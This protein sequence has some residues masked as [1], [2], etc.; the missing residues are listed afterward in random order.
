MS[1][2][3]LKFKYLKVNLCFGYPFGF[4]FLVVDIYN[5]FEYFKKTNSVQVILTR[6]RVGFFGFGFFAP[7]PNQDY[8]HNYQI[9]SSTMLKHIFVD[10][11]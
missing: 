7:L 6:V 4:G 1:I 8:L 10:Y 11:L 2:P 3:Y 9:T 5:S